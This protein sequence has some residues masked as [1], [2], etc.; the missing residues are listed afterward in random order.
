MFLCS[1]LQAHKGLTSSIAGAVR[2]SSSSPFDGP[3]RDLVNFPRPK[4]LE[5]NGPVRYGF[6]PEEFFDFFY[7]KTGVTGILSALYAICITLC[8]GL[9]V[10]IN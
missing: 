8:R 10:H 7:K 5:K 3:E 6:I 1:A 4:R 9:I 2:A